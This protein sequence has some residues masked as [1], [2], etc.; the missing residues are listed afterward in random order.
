MKKKKEKKDYLD[1]IF[2]FSINGKVKNKRISHVGVDTG[3]AV[4][5]LDQLARA[6]SIGEFIATSNSG[7]T[8]PQILDEYKDFF[9]ADDK[10]VDE[11]VQRFWYNR[12]QKLSAICE[13]YK[14]LSDETDDKVLTEYFIHKLLYR[15]N[16]AP[17]SGH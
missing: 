13:E 12:Q 4:F 6:Y 1:I 15:F 2:L 17:I 5:G 16:S 14:G 3:S 9:G 8:L 10:E 11:L 7:T